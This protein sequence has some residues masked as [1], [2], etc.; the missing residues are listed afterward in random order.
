MDAV[1]HRF[2]Y[3]QRKPAQDFSAVIKGMGQLQLNLH[4]T[5]VV[6]IGVYNW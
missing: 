3:A 5:M 4:V 1:L 2:G 6:A